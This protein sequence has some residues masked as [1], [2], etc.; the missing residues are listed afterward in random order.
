VGG[1]L[2]D[3]A[4]GNFFGMYISTCYACMHEAVWRVM[5]ASRAMHDL[6]TAIMHAVV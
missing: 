3:F 2:R 1:F 4:P 6:G 5:A